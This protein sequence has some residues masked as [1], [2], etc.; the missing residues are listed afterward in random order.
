MHELMHLL[1]EVTRGGPLVGQWEPFFPLVLDAAVPDEASGNPSEMCYKVLLQRWGHSVMPEASLAWS[2]VTE[3][4]ISGHFEDVLSSSCPFAPSG[5][6]S[7]TYAVSLVSVSCCACCAVPQAIVLTPLTL[8]RSC[9]A[10]LEFTVFCI[11]QDE[12]TK[13]ILPGTLPV[14]WHFS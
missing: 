4:W 14:F 2:W 7:H 5:L 13:A 6:W 11:E 9:P 1:T 8:S 10:F 12:K 3:S